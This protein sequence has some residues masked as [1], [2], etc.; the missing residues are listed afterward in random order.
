[1]NT[2]D[3]GSEHPQSRPSSAAE[4][5]EFPDFPGYPGHDGTGSG[6]AGDLLGDCRR[7]APRWATPRAHPHEPVPPSRIHGTTVPEASRHAVAG[8]PDYGG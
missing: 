4:P 5:P 1:M 2:S 6:S 7:I 3:R 8:M